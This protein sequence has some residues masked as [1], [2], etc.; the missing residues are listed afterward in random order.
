MKRSRILFLTLGVLALTLCL[1]ACNHEHTF[2]TKIVEA[3]TCT[4]AGLAYEQCTVCNFKTE[5]KEVAPLGH[6]IVKD[7]GGHNVW[8]SDSDEH[9]YSCSRCE[10]KIYPDDIA[11]AH[12]LNADK[13]CEICGFA[14]FEYEETADGNIL[15]KYNGKGGEVEIPATYKEEA[16]VGLG[17]ELFY[18]NSA[19][20]AIKLPSSI[21][22]IGEDAFLNCSKLQTVKAASIEAWLKIKFANYSANPMCVASDLYLGENK[23]GD[24]VNIPAGTQKIGEFAFV[25]LESLTSV[26]I[27]ESVTE[28]GYRAF[29]DAFKAG[30]RGQ[31]NITNLQKWCAIE[32]SVGG[33]DVGECSAN[34]ISLGADLVLNGNTVSGAQDFGAYDISAYAFYGYDQIEAVTSAAQNVGRYA[35]ANCAKLKQ[36]TLDSAVAI[37]A[38]L[39]AGCKTLDAI[40]I[41]AANAIG[42]SAFE[43]CE[44]LASINIPASVI[45][46]GEEAFADCTALASV[47]GA[48]G[49]TKVG[50]SAFFN[51]KLF[52]LSQTETFEQVYVGKVFVGLKGAKSGNI[53]LE[54]RTDTV[55]IADGAL[56]NYA[57]I[58]SV[59]CPASMKYIGK[60]ALRYTEIVT[61]K[62]AEIDLCEVEEIGE[63][64]FAGNA[65]LRVIQLPSTLQK[66]GK[67]AFFGCSQ[68]A[69]V[70]IEDIQALLNI[71]FANAQANPLAISHTLYFGTYDADATEQPQAVTSLVIPDGVQKIGAYAFYGLNKVTNVILPTSL[72][73]IETGAFENCSA[74][75]Y[76]YYAGE[77]EEDFAAVSVA[78]NA[79]PGTVYYFSAEQ[80][81]SRGNFWHYNTNEPPAPIRW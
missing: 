73:T 66:V 1:A 24:S 60:N 8:S 44:A 54:F 65:A 38:G 26:T 47:A 43:G 32:F 17:K 55:A 57:N 7:E 77:S 33:E 68:I 21:T 12:S 59:K 22:S 63:Q 48:D 67:N 30:E 79:L 62:L 5:Q 31:V 15:T 49:L 20:T 36:A 58:T 14:T 16:V 41:S 45:S 3:A 10:E 80:P 56:A 11:A 52:E 6:D 13:E 39:F 76:V 81:E 29:K 18:R 78:A 71:Q 25:G 75:R 42:A 40:S 64:A 27:P 4:Q 37:Q 2:E 19:V 61:S 50:E 53:Q 35:F 74:L 34:P 23:L 9:W 72:E 70:Y 69:G 28:I 46:V 51:T